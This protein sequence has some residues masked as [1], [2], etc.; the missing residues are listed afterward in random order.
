MSEF[1][2]AEAHLNFWIKNVRPTI[3]RDP[4]PAKAA[5]EPADP[6]LEAIMAELQAKELKGFGRRVAP[7]WLRDQAECIL[8]GR[9]LKAAEKAKAFEAFA[10]KAAIPKRFKSADLRD[11]VPFN[12]VQAQALKTVKA[13]ARAVWKGESPWLVLS[14]TCGTGKSMMACAALNSLAGLQGKAVQ[15][16]A[17]VDLLGALRDGFE[18]GR[19]GPS[20]AQLIRDLSRV[21]V[22]CLDDVAAAPSA[23]EAKELLKIIDARYR[24]ELPTIIVSNLSTRPGA[25]GSPSELE[26][27]LGNVAYSRLEE[28]SLFAAC[29]TVDYR[30]VRRSMK[31]AA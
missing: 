11:F 21:D 27:F 14:G 20:E 15:F 2:S 1:L 13:W 25:D 7:D 12:E 10:Q 9:R 17:T 6:E 23:F 26:A 19:T 5:A 22:L 4:V 16:V 29:V 30:K 31:E 8:A 18:S 28:V 24:D 3:P